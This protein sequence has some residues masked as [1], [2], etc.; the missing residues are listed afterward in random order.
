MTTT[1]N[2]ANLVAIKANLAQL[3][4]T[5]DQRA[6][7]QIRAKLRR[8]GHYGAAHVSKLICTK[9]D[10]ARLTARKPDATDDQQ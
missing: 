3:T 5:T 9:V 4:A 6:K 2:K 8:L 10:A 1:T 7:K